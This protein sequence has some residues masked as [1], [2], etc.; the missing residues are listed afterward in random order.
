[1][2][3][4]A[5]S[6]TPS[7]HSEIVHEL[8]QLSLVLPSSH[9]SPGLT[10]PSGQWGRVPLLWQLSLLLVLPSSHSSTPVP[11][12]HTMPSP[13]NGASHA[14]VQLSVLTVLPSSQSSN[15]DWVEP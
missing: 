10:L 11:S 14:L 12:L 7:P 6:V 1:M 5:R 8:V 3:G 2:P 13:Q 4:D 15:S 9:S